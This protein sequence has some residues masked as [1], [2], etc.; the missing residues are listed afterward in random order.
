[1]IKVLY[2]DDELGLLE[3]AKAFLETTTDICLETVTNARD[4]LQRVARGGI[5]VIVSDYMMPGMDG[6]AFLKEIRS[7]G[8]RTPFI[9]FTGRGREDV[10]IQALNGGADFYLQKGGAPIPQYAE[11]AHKIKL[12]A[13]R[14]RTDEALKESERRFRQVLEA[15]P[16]GLWLADKD[17]RLVLGNPAGQRIWEGDPHVGQS[18][19]G[20][21]RAWRLP[22]REPVRADDWALSH[23]VNEGRSTENELLEIEA[24][25]GSQKYILNWAIPLKDEEGGITGA[26]VINQ[27]I[28]AIKRAEA[29]LREREENYRALIRYSSDPIFSYNPDETYRFVNEA[30]AQAFGKAPEDIIGRTPHDLFSH[31]EAER[32]LRL[33]RQVFWTGKKGEIEVR[34]VT[35]QG[36]VKHFLTI[37][38][39]ITDES[40]TVLAV[41][42]ISKDI[43]ERKKVEDALRKSEEMN[44]AI[45]EHAGI[46]MG[47]W[48]LSGR[49]LYMNTMAAL[50]LGGDPEKYMGRNMAD[51]FD[52]ET[53]RVYQ[54]RMAETVSSST[55]REY[56]DQVTLP[57]GIA[58]F[59]SIYTRVLDP[60][61]KVTGVQ[62]LSHDITSRKMVERT[63][64][65]ANQKLN[66]LSGVTRHD[67]GNQL[68]VM[69][70]LL[71]LAKAQED[72]AK[73]IGYIDRASQ[74]G[75]RIGAMIRFTKDY[76]E[77]GVLAPSWDNLRYVV[78][79][80]W[81]GAQHNEMQF[82]NDI[83]PAVE[84][85]ADPLIEKVFYNLMDNAANHGRTVTA[86]RCWAEEV[87]GSLKIFVEDD[88]IGVMHHE[89]EMIFERGY[90][91]DHGLGL[92]LAREI[93]GMTHIAIRETGVPFQGARFELT[94]P[95]G[96]FRR[97]DALRS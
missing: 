84:C 57:D 29:S 81:A 94:V 78:N 61:G 7:G 70:G 76:E 93:L 36:E 74:A 47:F 73:A 9:L 64:H 4:G 21:F 11:L 50:Q 19:Y 88:G 75:D 96:A 10:V 37:A 20:V 83:D 32:R 55:L 15:L 86:I 16:I 30:F 39:P 8:D 34:V 6:L 79:H 28:T 17:G 80:A 5:D 40:G 44:R 58:W 63:L 65:D 95:K 77:I 72:R 66:L 54:K 14:R 27:D 48:D 2:V 85:F 38:D 90:G 26:F 68:L 1:M 97:N 24:L 87:G 60:A 82:R 33:V 51:L 18:E 3:L 91:K 45:L 71:Q 43:T 59:L 56:E 62:I 52:Q 69:N 25:D 53:A 22:A 12:A 92:F 67:I 13:E 31:D 42:C 49:L 89:K 41:S 46:G 35:F 23:A